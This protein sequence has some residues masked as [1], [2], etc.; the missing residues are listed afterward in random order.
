MAQS[1]VANDAMATAIDPQKKSLRGCNSTILLP[2]A[3]CAKG[4]V[5]LALLFVTECCRSNCSGPPPFRS[6]FATLHLQVQ[7]LW[8]SSGI[9]WLKV[10]PGLPNSDQSANAVTRIVSRKLLKESSLSSQCRAPK[11]YSKTL[12]A[13]IRDILPH[14]ASTLQDR[15]CKKLRKKADGDG[16]ADTRSAA[17]GAQLVE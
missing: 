2:S 10:E 13:T 15:T 14:E 11:R 3:S 6:W 8:P 5:G 1:T 4:L 17:C 7:T 16:T 12:V 9:I